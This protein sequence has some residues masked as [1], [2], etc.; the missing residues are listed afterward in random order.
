LD[1]L[2]P[3]VKGRNIHDLGCAELAQSAQLVRLGVAHITAVDK[4]KYTYPLTKSKKVEFVRSYFKDYEGT[5]ETAFISW[6]INGIACAGLVIYI[7]KNTDGTTCGDKALWQ[8]LSHRDVLVYKPHS[9][10]T[11]IIYGQYH[12][13]FRLLRGEER[14]ALVTGNYYQYREVE[15]TT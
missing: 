13:E 14:G 3:Y 7:G 10:S 11:L 1:A 12:K 4:E 9:F 2:A 5:V 6:P 15:A 8:H